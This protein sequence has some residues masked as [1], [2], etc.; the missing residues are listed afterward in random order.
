MAEGAEQED[1][2]EEPT[3]RRIDQAIER[4]DVANSVEINTFFMLGAFTL[5]L[6]LTA[7]PVATTL[8][9]DIRG[10]L[11]NAHAIPLDPH[12]YGGLGGRILIIFLQ[13][14]AI[15]AA[16]VG[17]AALAAGM[18]Q[19]RPVF[20]AQSLAPKFERISPMSGM[21]RLLGVEALF[22]FGKGLAKLVVVGTV[23]GTILWGER[24]RLESFAQLDPGS[25]LQAVL[26]L[27][28]KM[29]GGVL[30]AYVA[31]A[32]GDALYQR[33]RWRSRLR[34]SKEELKQEHKE[35]EGNPEVKGKRKQLMHARVK[36]RMMAAVP[37]A[38]VVVTNP[39]HFAVALRY[40]PGMG[41]PICVAKGVDSLAFRIRSVATDAGVP[42][43]E[44]PPLARALHATVEIDDEIP[45]EH[46][47]A[48]AEVI[49]FV[50]RLRKRAA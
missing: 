17:A 13:A 10:F 19:H 5:A 8:M 3:Q 22:Q 50:L 27:S 30:A 44:N 23:A 39:T 48:V 14:V 12:A 40:E 29:M 4:G 37:T 18:I 26:A 9:T 43:I 15:P 35:S 11:A 2:T 46:Y 25:A 34:M 47:R 1:K 32:L 45:A 21:K 36:K 16:M 49:G 6:M 41:A 33:H 20:T 24:D 28:L 38:T 7:G 31:I 42:V